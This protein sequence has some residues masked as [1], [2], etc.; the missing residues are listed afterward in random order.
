VEIDGKKILL[1]NVAGTVCA[2]EDRCAH[3]GWPLSH[4]KLVGQELTCA[5]HQWR[6]DART[7]VGLNPRGV[8]LRSYG[9]QILDGDILV[10]LD[11]A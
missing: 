11:G 7:G 9:V 10:D 6:Y 1:V 3:L 2:F 5:L 8:V 4:G